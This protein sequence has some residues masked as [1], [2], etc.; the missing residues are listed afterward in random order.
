MSL[1][2]AHGLLELLN[3]IFHF[4]SPQ[5]MWLLPLCSVC[6]S[7]SPTPD[8]PPSIVLLPTTVQ[9]V[10]S[11]SHARQLVLKEPS[12]GGAQTALAAASLWDSLP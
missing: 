2:V 3:Q 8:R 4:S 11:P 12:M 6:P 9:A 1:Q 10:L 5:V 7:Q